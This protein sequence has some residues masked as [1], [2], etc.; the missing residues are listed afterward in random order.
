MLT[1]MHYSYLMM[2]TTQTVTT[3]WSWKD[4]PELMARLIAIQNDGNHEHQDIVTYAGW[5]G[6]EA[7]LI[8]HIE[9]N[10]K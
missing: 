2:N 7:E 5:C 6:S 1:A 9:R 8:R 10:E 3:K 4:S